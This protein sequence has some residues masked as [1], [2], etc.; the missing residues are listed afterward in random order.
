[1][2]AAGR[3]AVRRIPE[4]LGA[5]VPRPGTQLERQCTLDCRL[6]G[7]R[8]LPKTQ[9]SLRGGRPGWVGN[10]RISYG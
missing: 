3:V 7:S 10:L 5:V 2:E 1:M 8:I 4:E 6:G 9:S